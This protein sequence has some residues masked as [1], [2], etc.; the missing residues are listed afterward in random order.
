MGNKSKRTFWLLS[1]IFLTWKPYLHHNKEEQTD[2]EEDMAATN[3]LDTNINP[4]LINKKQDTMIQV[5]Q[6][7][8]RIGPQEAAMDMSTSQL[9]NNNGLPTYTPIPHDTRSNQVLC[10]NRESAMAAG[11][12]ET[13]Q[14]EYQ[15]QP[16]EPPPSPYVTTQHQQWESCYFNSKHKRHDGE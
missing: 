4:N 9:R 8:Y 13:Q 11:Q 3:E 12:M 7:G 16:A 15:Q 6:G 1:L 14:Y 10:Q 5:Q 2:Q